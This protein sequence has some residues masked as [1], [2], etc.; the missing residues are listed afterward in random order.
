MYKYHLSE[1][2]T[3][4]PDKK[5][6][7]CKWVL[8]TKYNPDGSV[9]RHK[10]RLVI[11]GCR[12]VYGIDYLETFAPVAKMSTV[13][14]LLAV[15]AMQGWNAYQ[16]DVTNAF[17]H[18]ELEDEVYMKLPAGYHGFGSRISASEGELKQHSH[19]L[20]CKLKKALYGLKQAPRLW[21]DKLKLALKNGGYQQSKA[22]YSLFTLTVKDSITLILVYV[23]DLL[24]TGSCEVQIGQ[25]KSLLCEQFHMKDIGPA[26]YFLGLEIA[27]T[28]DGLFVSQRKYIQDLLKSYGMTKV[29]PLKLPM[30]THIKLTADKGDLLPNPHIFQ[31]LMG[32]LIYLTITRPDLAFPVQNLAQ[33]MHS[34]TTVHMQAAK[35]ILRYLKG[36]SDQGILFASSSAAQLTAYCDSDWASCPTTRKSTTGF[37][38][39]LGNSPISWKTK[40][41][42]VVSRSSAEAEY[43]AMAL[44]SCEITWLATLL[45]DMGITDLP[46]T[47]LKCDNQ[48]ALSIAANPVLHERTKHIEIDCHYVR[49]KIASGE[50]VTQYVPSH[51]QIADL[52]TKQLSVKQHHHLHSKFGASAKHSS[53]LEGE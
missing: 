34:P 1:I 36:N 31:R 41:Q 27:K 32:K 44:T 37:C 18:G 9:E 47:L 29:A 3:L 26:S 30:D 12:Q 48:A 2:T 25:L 17:L 33:F 22:D 8:K 39:F 21:F 42:S 5:A 28:A 43:R 49:D 40:K 35:R 50:I 20:V 11:L 15:T 23:D 19:N 7:G 53:P 6:I 46:P 10:A 24:I 4:P 16:M 14:S 38:I 45:K 51:A 52:L 13:R